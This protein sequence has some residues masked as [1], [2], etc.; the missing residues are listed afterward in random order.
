PVPGVPL[1]LDAAQALVTEVDEESLALLFHVR[2]V[3]QLYEGG[4][5]V[6]YGNDAPLPSDETPADTAL[7]PDEA[8]PIDEILVGT[9]DHL[10]GEQTGGDGRDLVVSMEELVDDGRRAYLARPDDRSRGAIAP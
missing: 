5:A 3:Y 1:Q 8:A 10:L 6:V 2:C 4:R 7:G 9:G